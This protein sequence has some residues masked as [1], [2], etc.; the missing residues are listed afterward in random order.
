MHGSKE[1]TLCFPEV[2]GLIQAGDTD[3]LTAIY[4]YLSRGLRPQI[5]RRVDYQD[6]PDILHDVFLEVVNAIQQNQL[7]DTKRLMGFARTIARRKV[8]L[9]MGVLIRTRRDQEQFTAVFQ[10]SDSP[11]PERTLMTRQHQELA[12]KTLAQLPERER[13]ILVRFY[14]QEQTQE[15]I[16]EEMNLSDTQFRLLKW[17]AKARLE[18]L[19]RQALWGRRGRKPRAAMPVS[20]P[21]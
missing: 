10:R 5:A 15:Q 8:A 9:Y 21:A 4:G 3:G 19:S 2:V 18:Q 20:I 16:C 12:T 14:I 13:N 17:R 6:V 11:C 1:P 7:R